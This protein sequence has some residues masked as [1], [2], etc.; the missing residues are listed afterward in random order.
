MHTHR[1]THF[2]TVQA[3]NEIAFSSTGK[4][5]LCLYSSQVHTGGCVYMLVFV[6]VSER[7]RE[8]AREGEANLAGANVLLIYFRL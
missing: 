2:T 8:R 6:C 5:E 1:R 3:G 4:S 7:E